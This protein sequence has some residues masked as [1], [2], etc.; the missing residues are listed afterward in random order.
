MELFGDPLLIK[1]GVDFCIDIDQKNV[2]RKI[3]R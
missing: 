1:N 2:D 3:K